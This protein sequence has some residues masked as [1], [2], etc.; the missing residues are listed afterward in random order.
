[1][2]WDSAAVEDA[3]EMAVQQKLQNSASTPLAAPQIRRFFHPLDSNSITAQRADHYAGTEQQRSHLLTRQLGAEAA[4]ELA[5]LVQ[6]HALA[7]DAASPNTGLLPV[8]RM[9]SS[10][11]SSEDFGKVREHSARDS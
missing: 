2:V 1:M 8:Q 9:T 5:A 3:V 6:A 7:V 4:Q 11:I 10:R